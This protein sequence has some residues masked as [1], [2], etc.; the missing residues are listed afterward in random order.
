[1]DMMRRSLPR[2]YSLP[3]AAA[4]IMIFFTSSSAPVSAQLLGQIEISSTLNPVGSGAR[5][6]GMGGAFIAVADDATA[7]SWNPGGLIQLEKPEIS[8]VGTFFER[9][10]NN[11]FRANREASGGQCVSELETNYLS[12]TYPFTF[13]GHNMVV[14]LSYQYLYDFNRYWNFTTIESIGPLASLTRNFE[15]T[16]SGGL[17][18][19]GLAYCIRITPSFSLGVTLNFWEDRL[20]KNDWTEDITENGS[21]ILGETPFTYQAN[22][23]DWY[24]FSG[25]NANIGLLWDIIPNLT[26]GAV[27]KTPF[28]ADLEHRYSSAFALVYPPANSAW[29]VTG[30]VPLTTA[31][32]ELQMP[33]SYGIGLAYRFSDELTVSADIYRTQWDD[34]THRDSWGNK[35]SPISG[36]PSNEANVNA[37]S[38]V[39]LGAEYLFIKPHYVIPLRGGV[40]YDPAPTEGGTDE[41]YGLSIGSGIAFGRYVFDVAYQYRFAHDVGHSLLQTMDFSQDIKEHQLYSSLIVHF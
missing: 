31:D 16:Q 39:R 37:T 26:L 9:S 18:A 33:M 20:S 19:I 11:T 40:F 5:A 3:S 13:R 35:S 14:S 22:S 24:S 27:V 25:F 1:M 6:L 41:F 21:G 38:Q 32:E 15:Y 7:A 29:D 8:L 17:S 34:F 10:E 2:G 30:S 12:L 28:T 36:K 23:T 4:L